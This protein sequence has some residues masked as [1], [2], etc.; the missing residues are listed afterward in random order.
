VHIFYYK[1]AQL[2]EFFA[3]LLDHVNELKSRQRESNHDTSGERSNAE[4]ASEFDLYTEFVAAKF[5]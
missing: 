1:P 2:H 5:E 4:E 3:A